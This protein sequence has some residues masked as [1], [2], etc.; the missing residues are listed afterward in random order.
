MKKTLFL[1]LAFAVLAGCGKSKEAKTGEKLMTQD[2]IIKLS[3]DARLYFK[4]LAGKMPGSET[5]TP[6][7]IALGEKLYNDTHLSLD[8]TVSCN[9]CHR[10][11]NNLGGAD[12]KPVATGVGGKHGTRNSPT[13]LNAG[14]Q[15]VQFWDGRAKDLEEQAKG[16]I[17]NP[18]EM[19][20]P[21]DKFVVNKVTGIAEYKEL[22]SKAFPK[23]KE[24]ITFDNI[25]RAIAAFERTLITHDRF[26]DYLN[27]NV[28]ALSQEEMKGLDL[29]ISTGCTT[30]HTGAML[31]G[32]LYQKI[33]LIH[34]YA[35]TTDK[36]RYAIT[37]NDA[38]MYMFKVPMLRDIAL[39]YPYFH[40]GKAAS[41]EEA[42]PQMAWMQLN[43]KL[44][45]EDA[46][47]IAKFLAALTDKSRVPKE[48]AEK[49]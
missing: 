47:Y 37:K 21:N 30:C 40:D 12:N 49:Q 15:F 46:K 2:Q 18:V 31:G 28:N 6:E 34:P 32:T 27:G 25:A 4:P 48:L 7:M 26:D 8:N 19:A 41:L 33:G 5:D 45:P 36:G 17:L 35:D 11:D 16:P 43:K 9:T 14:F 22:F 42:I 39:T 29:F 38:D 44:S 13:V 23:D 3:G 24:P 20:M 1:L 10:L